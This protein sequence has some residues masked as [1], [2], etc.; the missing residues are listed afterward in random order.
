MSAPDDRPTSEGRTPSGLGRLARIFRRAS[1]SSA[2]QGED[3]VMKTFSLGTAEV[4]EIDADSLTVLGSVK[5]RTFATLPDGREIELES[6]DLPPFEEA[7]PVLTGEL[8]AVQVKQSRDPRLG[9]RGG[10]VTERIVRRAWV[11][12][13]GTY[14]GLV[15]RAEVAAAKR[16]RAAVP[17]LVDL[18]STIAILDRQDRAPV[19]LP[20]PT[21]DI[22]GA[23]AG[24]DG[25]VR[26]V[27]TDTIAG[28]RSKMIPPVERGPVRGIEAIRTWLEGRGIGLDV[29]DGH[30]LATATRLGPAE[31]EVITTFESL[32]V[33]H[34]RGEPV[35]CSLPHKGPIVPAFTYAIPR[36]PVCERHLREDRVA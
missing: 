21:Y 28:S 18:A 23:M 20:A 24:A 1:S 26:R 19:V 30:L 6:R 16:A 10:L 36:L 2:P 3:T 4:E 11:R 12:P 35:P 27:A 29:V 33:G 13:E 7:N 32:L 25:S 17:R 14:A 34:L 22:G 5:H 15:A 31:A 9:S 8:R